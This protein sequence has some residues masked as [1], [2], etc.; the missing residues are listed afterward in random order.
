M[1]F[2][3]LTYSE[4]YRR[5]TVHNL[6]CNFRCRGCAYKLKGGHPK[7]ER[8]PALEEFKEALAGLECDR[9]HFMGGEPTTCAD[10]D[11]MLQFCREEL[12]LTA[13]LGHSNGSKL[14]GVRYDFTNVSFKAWEPERYLDYTGQPGQP[15]Y[16]NFR[17]AF[18]RGVAMKAS[19]VYI[20]E[21]C[22]TD[23]ILRM[24]EFVA[25]VS[26][27]IPFHIMGYMPVPGAPWRR[28]TDEEM[29]A[30]VAAVKEILPQVGFSHLSS[31]QGRDLSARD[32][33]FKVVQVL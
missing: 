24:A 18:D 11:E 23:Q 16:D 33:R 27:E 19:T 26:A 10:L 9:V 25:A 3:K 5:A 8:I 31:E 21:F 17:L 13:G 22:E 6:G 30:V 1:A 7:P 32:D 28:P 14:P 12:G 4:Q 29:A 20:P 15:I 2:Y